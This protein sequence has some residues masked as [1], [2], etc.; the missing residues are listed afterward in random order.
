[1]GCWNGIGGKLEKGEPAREAMLREIWEETHIAPQEL[2]FKGLITWSTVEG[3]GFGG[4]YL[5][6]ANVPE[7]CDYPTPHPTEEGILDW[8][9]IDW[10]M[11][12]KN[13]GVAA[14]IP[15]S[16]DKVLNDTAC[17]RHHS[18]FQGDRFVK[19]VS[20]WV[21]PRIEYDERLREEYVQLCITEL[22]GI[23]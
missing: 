17:Y 21:D 8:K 16:L 15:P 11:H 18:Y 1:M 2:L 5:Y 12:P 6:L 22:T 9:D 3:T 23:R 14:N 10:I 7:D 19:Q 13:Q 20:S 4:M